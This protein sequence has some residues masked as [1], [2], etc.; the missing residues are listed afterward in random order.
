LQDPIRAVRYHATR[1]FPLEE[2]DMTQAGAEAELNILREQVSQLLRKEEDR[3]KYWRQL[4]I[5]SKV[6]AIAA[7]AT[8]LAFLVFSN[9]LDAKSY[10][11]TH[12]FATIMGY[13]LFFIGYPLLLLG[14]ALHRKRAS[15]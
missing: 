6:S 4:G 2:V 12:V 7:S 9:L 10:P 8:G 5:V 11:S 15:K 1:I 3:D 13:Q 14:A